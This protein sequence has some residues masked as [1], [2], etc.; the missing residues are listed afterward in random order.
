MN[1]HHNNIYQNWEYKIKHGIFFSIRLKKLKMNHPFL[2]LH[3]MGEL[4]FRQC[5][6]APQIALEHVDFL[7]S[8]YNEGI[9]LLLEGNLLGRDLVALKEEMG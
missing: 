1:H 8:G 9:N 7:N 5:E 2:K 6:S 4:S 3:F